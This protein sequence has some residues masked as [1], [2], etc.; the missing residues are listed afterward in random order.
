MDLEVFI[1]GVPN[2][3]KIWGKNDDLPYIQSFYGRS[4]N[5]EIKF[6]IELR[7][8]NSR[9]YCYY[10]YLKCRNII[11][12]DGRSGS[13]FGISIRID[14][15]CA[16]FINMYRLMDVVYNKYVFGY[17][18]N[19]NGESIKYLASDFR[20][21]ICNGI[22]HAI[23]TLIRN[24]FN[25]KDFTNDLQRIRIVNSN[26]IGKINILDCTRENVWN[27][28]AHEG[29]IAISPYYLSIKENNLSVEFNREKENI[30]ASKNLEIQ[31]IQREY[32]IQINKLQ[33][34]LS[35]SETIKNLSN[36][37]L[38]EQFDKEKA[39]C[40]LEINRLRSDIN[41]LNE[42]NQKLKNSITLVVNAIKEYVPTSL[43]ISSL[44]LRTNPTERID[45]SKMQINGMEE[46]KKSCWKKLFGV[47]SKEP[48]IIIEKEK[49]G[50]IKIRSEK[51]IVKIQNV[52]DI[53]G[54]KW[55]VQNAQIIRENEK[56][57]EIV[58]YQIGHVLIQYSINNNIVVQRE[59]YACEEV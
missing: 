29:V 56:E 54:G 48:L 4:D 37:K 38:R 9:N 55:N 24:L 35:E 20:D 1:H 26:R 17:I 49:N 46:Q 3:Q 42:E 39:N 16:D 58:V 25:D 51:Y 31:N 10:S 21:D 45:Q 47:H 53:R 43:A 14:E 23:E 13:Y 12:F 27:Y 6:L 5:E 34:S 33:D 11:A 30:I 32:N 52:K 7:N 41:K 59:T 19:S 36:R 2:G 8:I 15:Y 50:R 28:L 57:C 40:E 22:K 18:L 44:P